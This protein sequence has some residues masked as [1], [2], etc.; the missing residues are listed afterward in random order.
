MECI[1]VVLVDGQEVAGD[2]FAD[3]GGCVGASM[4]ARKRI[5]GTLC[6]LRIL[7]T[8]EEDAEVRGRFKTLTV[9]IT[10]E[11]ACDAEAEE[12]ADAEAEDAIARGEE[13]LDAY[14]ASL[15]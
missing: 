15:E 10:T 1:P 11:G 14:L 5:V 3:P 13:A 6:A 9:R 12:R 4:D 2:R 7:R 8:V